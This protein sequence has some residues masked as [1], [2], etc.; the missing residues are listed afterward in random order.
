MA[1]EASTYQTLR[2]RLLTECP[3]IDDKTLADTLEGIESARQRAGCR[4]QVRE[5]SDPFAVPARPGRESQ[6]PVTP[7][8]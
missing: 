8:Q 6:Q 5:G 7:D 2:V 3:R 1:F 4:H